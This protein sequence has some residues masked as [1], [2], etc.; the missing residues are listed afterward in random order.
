[1]IRKIK[2]WRAKNSAGSAYAHLVGKDET[3]LSDHFRTENAGRTGFN[4]VFCI[5]DNKTG[6]TSIEAVFRNLGLH[7]PKQSHQERL[8]SHVL[9]SGRYDALVRFVRNFD[10]FQDAPFSQESLYIALDASFPNSKFILTLR[11]PNAWFD[12]LLGFHQK[13]FGFEGSGAPEM[14][15][16]S[17]KKHLHENYTFEQMKRIATQ[18]RNGRITIDWGRLYDRDARISAFNERNDAI[19]RYFR[20]RPSD[21]L[22]IDL[23]EEADTTKICRFLGFDDQHIQDFPRLNAR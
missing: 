8:T 11:E 10:A 19:I 1:M 3:A 2:A 22:C 9:T 12:S 20:D 4:K 23:A 16:W 15:F 18:V 7:V 14:S 6:T 5:G 13:F 21:L 17:G